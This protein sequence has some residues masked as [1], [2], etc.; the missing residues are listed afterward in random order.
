MVR[1]I[2][3]SHVRDKDLTRKL[4]EVALITFV[5]GQGYSAILHLP[6]IGSTEPATEHHKIVA[7]DGVRAVGVP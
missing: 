4:H 1:T 2:K 5:Q 7:K 6:D 3:W